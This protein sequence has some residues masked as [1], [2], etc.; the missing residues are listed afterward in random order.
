[1]M[2]GKSFW[3][4]LALATVVAMLVFVS[5]KANAQKQ[6]QPR[7]SGPPSLSL[8]A[9]S[10]VIKGCNDESARVRLVAT[11]TSADGAPPRAMGDLPAMT[12]ESKGLATELKRRG[13]RFV[14]PTTAYA[15]MQAC[16][17]V[18]DHLPGCPARERAQSER[19]AALRA[20]GDRPA[21]AGAGPD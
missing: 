11:A 15:G 9:D 17:I 4:G 1:M 21:D 2:P 5:P 20:W 14:G 12:D 19:E 8:A 16:G 6:K 18:N 10:A 7:A 13:F 3:S